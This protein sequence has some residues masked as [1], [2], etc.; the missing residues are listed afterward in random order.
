[1]EKKMSENAGS[2]SWFSTLPGVLTAGAAFITAFAT[3]LAAVNGMFPGLFA[4]EEIKPSPTELIDTGT[5]GANDCLPPYVWRLAFPKDRVC[6]ATETYLRAQQ[7][8]Q[9]AGT[10]RN[11]NGGDYG[12]DTCLSGYVFRD[13]FQGDR[14]CVEV[15]TREQAALDNQA[16]QSRRK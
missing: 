10:R 7:D 4:S 11:P 16:A 8:N 9:L 6:V 15:P 13:A 5:N 14:V 3:L 12:A 1:V 2:K